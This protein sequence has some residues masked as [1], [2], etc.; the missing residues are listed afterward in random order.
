MLTRPWTEGRRW[1]D[2]GGQGGGRKC[3]RRLGLLRHKT[4]PCCLC[5]TLARACVCSV[6][7]CIRALACAWSFSV[8]AVQSR[9]MPASYPHKSLCLCARFP[10]AGNPI[11]RLYQIPVRVPCKAEGRLSRAQLAA[12]VRRRF[13]P[14]IRAARAAVEACPATAAWARRLAERPWPTGPGIR[15]ESDAEASGKENVGPPSQ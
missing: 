10:P 8:F 6:C 4:A 2:C 13:G 1:R 11:L 3:F 12:E 9:F 14:R 5:N 7:E 15:S